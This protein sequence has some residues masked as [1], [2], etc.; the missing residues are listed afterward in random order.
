MGFRL[1]R[2]AFVQPS[3]DIAGIAAEH[4]RR[5]RGNV[6]GWWSSLMFRA[7]TRGAPED[8]A[9]MMSFLLFDGDYAADLIDLGQHDAEQYESELAAL[10][11]E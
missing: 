7:L 10:F 5:M 3:Q 4:V 2:D 9:D 1:V 8:E 11:V 6:P